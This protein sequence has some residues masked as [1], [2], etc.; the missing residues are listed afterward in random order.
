[1][2]VVG[3]PFVAA[4]NPAYAESPY[5]PA[6]EAAKFTALGGR[7]EDTIVLGHLTE[8]PEA[9]PGEE[10]TELPRGRG[11][12]FP[13]AACKAKTLVNGH[14]HRRQ[15][16]SGIWMPG[17]LARLTFGEETHDPGFLILEV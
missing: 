16:A 4:T 7:E 8:I 5:A 10:T 17:A 3:L 13:V 1:V 14:F 9:K 12:P 6:V 11:I 2:T 15:K